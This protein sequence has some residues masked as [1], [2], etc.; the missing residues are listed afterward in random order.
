MMDRS[1]AVPDGFVVAQFFRKPLTAENFRMHA[2]YQHFLV[3][4]TIEHTDPSALGK[5]AR[6][7]PEK[8]MFQFFGARLFETE[9]LATLRVYSRHYVPNRSVFPRSGE[10]EEARQKW[11]GSEAVAANSTLLHVLPRGLCSPLLSRKMASASEDHDHTRALASALASGL[12]SAFVP[13][14]RFSRSAFSKSSTA[15][16]SSR[17]SSS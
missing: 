7:S 13:S 4:G 14:F 15:R 11:K 2:N 9:Y 12:A 8:I 5:A 17:P 1:T 10:A 16:R 3:I 6:R